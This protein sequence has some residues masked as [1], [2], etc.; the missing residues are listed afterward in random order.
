MAIFLRSSGAEFCDMNLILDDRII[1]AHKSILAAR[2]SYFQGMFRSFMP[3]DNTVNVRNLRQQFGILKMP[4]SIDNFLLY[5]HRFKLV[6]FHLHKNH[7][8]HYCDTFTTEKYECHPK[9]H[10]ISFKHL[11]FMVN[12]THFSITEN[13]LLI[14]R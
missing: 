5:V 12:T 10:Y 8:I 1:P 13:I 11:A 7:S 6:I 2:C 9:T 4:C 14:S 3:A